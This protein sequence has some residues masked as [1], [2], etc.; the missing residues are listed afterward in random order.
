MWSLF[1]A[2]WTH[3][4]NLRCSW[5]VHF[6][7]MTW[8]SAEKQKTKHTHSHIRL[9]W[10]C[11][12][13]TASICVYQVCLKRVFI[14]WQIRH[15]L[16]ML[17]VLCVHVTNVKMCDSRNEKG[18]IIITLIGARKSLILYSKERYRCHCCWFFKFWLVD[19]TVFSSSHFLF[20]LFFCSRSPWI[21]GKS[22]E[23]AAF[24]FF[25]FVEVLF[26]WISWDQ[27]Y[28]YAHICMHV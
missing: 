28:A 13:H 1:G 24:F 21:F 19:S 17:Q 15:T 27:G 8:C 5:T 4:T 16:Y 2:G 6:K 22:A 9:H 18:N 26:A 23:M 12:R 20:V 14:N 3:D 10:I 11:I 25:S 7:M